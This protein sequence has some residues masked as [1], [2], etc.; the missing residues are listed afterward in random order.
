MKT[1]SKSEKAK[2]WKDMAIRLS[3]CLDRHVLDCNVLS[4]R[5][6][7]YHNSDEPCPVV[8]EI[9]KTNDDF[10]SLLSND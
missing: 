1:Q 10:D 4:H 6:D 2:A 5:K 8:A 7:E 9:L 3:R